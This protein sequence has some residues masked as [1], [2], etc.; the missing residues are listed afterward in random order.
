MPAQLHQILARDKDTKAHLNRTITAFYHTAQ[1]KD[2]FAGMVKTYQPHDEEGTHLPPESVLVQ[3]RTGHVLAGVREAFSKLFALRADI[4]ES[5]RHAVATIIIDG[6]PLT[7]LLPTTHLLF[8]EKQVNDIATVVEALPTLD[9]AQ[10][11]AWNSQ[12]ELWQTEELKT[13]RTV[14]KEEFVTI[15]PATDKHPAQVAKVAKDVQEGMWVTRK[16]SG[17]IPAAEKAKMLGRIAEVKSAVKVAITVANGTS[18]T[19]SPSN[20]ILDFIFG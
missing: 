15:A 9:P 20:G 2:L 12:E 19:E 10:I 16:L 1:K 7:G 5:N 3:K 4:D 8:L 18:V 11:W 13:A 14:K 6:I 17:A